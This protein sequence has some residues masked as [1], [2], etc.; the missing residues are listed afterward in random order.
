[1]RS[2]RNQILFLC[3]GVVLATSLATLIAFSFNTSQYSRSQIDQKMNAATITFHELLDNRESQLKISASLLTA[4][5]GFKQAVATRDSATINSVLYNHGK[6]AQADLM[7]LTDLKGIIRASTHPELIT[8]KHFPYASLIQAAAFMQDGAVSFME[9]NG[10]LYQIALVPVN[11]P[12]PIAF[13]GV[14]FKL[15]LAIAQEL[16]ALTNLEVTFLTH[17][18][19]SRKIKRTITTL[20]KEGLSQALNAEHEITLDFGLFLPNKT[21]YISRKVELEGVQSNLGSAVLSIDL[22]DAFSSHRNLKNKISFISMSIFIIAIAGSLVLAENVSNP[23]KKLVLIAEKITAGR[24]DDNFDEKSQTRE[25][26]TL[27]NAFSAMGASIRLR[28]ERIT[29]QAEHDSLTNLFNRS[30]LLRNIDENFTRVQKPYVT[31]SLNIRGFRGIND[32]FGQGI[33]DSILRSVA[34]R[35]TSYKS[36]DAFSARLSADEFVIAIDIQAQSVENLAQELIDHLHEP[37]VIDRLT[38]NVHFSAGYAI[39]PQHG[40][41]SETLMRRSAIALDKSRHAQLTLRCYEVGEDEEHLDQLAIL[42]DLKTALASDD[43]QL[44]MNYQPKLNL[45]NWKVDK[46]EALIRWQH[47]DRGFI[48]PELFIA[49]AEQSALIADITDWVIQAVITQAAEWRQRYPELQVA[50]NISSQDLE[51]TELLPMIESLLTRTELPTHVICLEMTERDMMS[52][53]D[54][55]EE[56][57]KKFQAAGF[58]LSID[59]YGIGQSSLSKLKQMPVDEIKIDKAFITHLDSSEA[60]QIIVKSTIELGHNFGLKVIAE[61]VESKGAQD[62]LSDLGCDYIQGYFLSRPLKP[63]DFDGWMT[64][65]RA[66]SN[67]A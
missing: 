11:A 38:F 36:G 62:I 15:D 67:Y 8:G 57:M 53:P 60:D 18:S 13:T 1:M 51:R 63:E 26:Q 29:Y 58:E 9:L 42:N 20:P 59:D 17:N 25:I 5:F 47:P 48:S 65:Q 33:G 66:Q 31:I 39:Y 27:F 21:S 61:G 64:T 50:I 44:H 19:S 28:E 43:G 30:A 22:F 23:L 49:L 34:S 12:R 3:V 24:Y 46:L 37:I 6:R 10:S 55:A 4:D 16:K 45:K 14:G 56:L 35:L 32:S 2:L 41:D 7:I 40:E 54:R 52:N